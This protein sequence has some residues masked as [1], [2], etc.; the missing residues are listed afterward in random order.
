[1]IP[2][3]R[4]WPRPAWQ[5]PQGQQHWRRCSRFPPVVCCTISLAGGDRSTWHGLARSTQP[6]ARRGGSTDLREAEERILRPEHDV[7]DLCSDGA[8][9]DQERRGIDELRPGRTHDL[10]KTHKVRLFRHESGA[11]NTQLTEIRSD[12]V[13]WIQWSDTGAGAGHDDIACENASIRQ[14]RLAC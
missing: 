4:G 11:N 3:R 10:P 13:S 2:T 6:G 1:M 14:R 7:A 5:L 12:L 9:A 8:G